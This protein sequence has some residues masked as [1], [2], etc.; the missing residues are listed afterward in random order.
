LLIVLASAGCSYLIPPQ[1][2]PLDRENYMK[3]VSTSWKEQLLNNLVMLRYGDTLTS[4]ELISVTTGYELDASLSAGYPVN[5]HP[6]SSNIESTTGFRNVVSVNG[7]AS[8]MDKPTITYNPMRGEALAKTMIEPLEPAKILKSL[9]TGWGANYIFPCC[10]KSINHLRNRTSSGLIEED[11][12]FFK[13]VELFG[14]LKK[15]GVIRIT[16]ETPEQPK[17]TKVPQEYTITLKDERKGTQGKEKSEPGKETALKVATKPRKE[18]KAE[19]KTDKK[20]EEKEVTET[21]FLVVDKDRAKFLDEKLEPGEETFTKKIERFKKLLWSHASQ[22]ECLYSHCSGCHGEKGD[23][24]GPK[25]SNCNS[26]PAD[27]TDL[28]FWMGDVDQKIDQAI[29]SGH[30]GMAKSAMKP[31]E[32]QAVTS[33][34]KQAFGR[35]EVYKIIDG[36]QYILQPDP[37]CDKI[38]LQTCSIWESLYILSQFINVPAEDHDRASPSKLYGKPL[39]GPVKVQIMFKIECDKKRPIDPFV[40]VQYHGYWFYI[41]GNN[42]LN[43]EVFS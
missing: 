28:K 16:I 38:V 2:I 8:Y 43:K 14:D 20:K 7:S 32:R 40:A 12:D 10:V 3:A 39:N 1:K 22:G 27:F 37:N 36:N 9:Q 26:N 33:Y 30:H 5:W 41:D 42:F 19:V 17:V 13:L 24:K 11:D 31:E 4:L 25:A 23:G 21:G 6:L 34:I 29:T 15:K 35:Y 18:K